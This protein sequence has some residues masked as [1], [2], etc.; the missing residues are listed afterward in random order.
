MN[1]RAS[2][3]FAVMNKGWRIAKGGHQSGEAPVLPEPESGAL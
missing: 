2:V 1:M 3:R